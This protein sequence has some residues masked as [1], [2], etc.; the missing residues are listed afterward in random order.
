MWNGC[1]WAGMEVVAAVADVTGGHL[2]RPGVYR[3]VPQEYE[4]SGW[5][6]SSTPP[7]EAERLEWS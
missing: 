4:A 5:P 1:D 3:S 7:G 6:T 2:R